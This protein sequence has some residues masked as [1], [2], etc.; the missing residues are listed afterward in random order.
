MI[1]AVS[2]L[3]SFSRCVN[4]IRRESVARCADCSP[5]ACSTAQ[6]VI[7]IRL[8]VKQLRYSVGGSGRR[9]TDRLQSTAVAW[10][11]WSGVRYDERSVEHEK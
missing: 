8:Y 9:L 5:A 10:R 4:M 3:S 7:I 11:R 6:S 1:A 2:D